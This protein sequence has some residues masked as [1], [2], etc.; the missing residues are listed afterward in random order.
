MK[1]W[2]NIT[3]AIPGCD[4]HNIVDDLLEL[5]IL[6]VTIKDFKDIK[7]SNWFHYHD[8]PL[9][10]SG[11]THSISLLLDAKVNSG[12]IVEKIKDKLKLCEVRILDE[13][14]YQDQDWVLRA[15]SNFQ[16]TQISKSLRILPPW[17]TIE[18]P[19]IKNVI[20]NPATGFGTGSHPTTKLC[21]CLLYTSPSP[22][23]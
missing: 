13:T 16:G 22:R 8:L 1:H 5:E 14:I 17:S 19:T 20:I 4:L 15:Q 2:K 9:K 18:D 23:D 10:F 12:E 21:I 11:D 7:S 3:L 6:S